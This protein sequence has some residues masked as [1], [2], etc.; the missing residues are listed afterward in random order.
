V[1]K[2]VEASR[3]VLCRVT[4]EHFSGQQREVTGEVIRSINVGTI[5]TVALV[6]LREKAGSRVLL[7]QAGVVPAELARVTRDAAVEAAKGA[8]ARGPHG[9]YRPEHYRAI[10]LR[11][12]E[13]D[14]EGREGVIDILCAEWS[15]LLG[16]Q[17]DR[18]RMRDWQKKATALGFL[19]PGKPG[20][21]A[22]RPGSNLYPKEKNDG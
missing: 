8:L 15:E 20:V 1:L 14:G 21:K 7:A 3:P 17:V 9:G 18:E 13:L 4:I 22:R 10:A 5:R 12:L 2:S 6:R 16:E 19:A 11:R